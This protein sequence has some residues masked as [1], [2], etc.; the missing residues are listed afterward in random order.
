MHRTAITLS[1]F[2][3]FALSIP[4]HATLINGG[5]EQPVI[6]PGEAKDFEAKDIPGW[7]FAS[8]QTRTIHRDFATAEGEQFLALNGVAA[9]YIVQE[10]SIVEG[11]QYQFDFF[12]SLPL[13]PDGNGIPEHA[14]SDTAGAF[15]FSLEYPSGTGLIPE[16]VELVVGP[17][18]RKIS[19]P[20][21]QL[22]SYQ[23]VAKAEAITVTFLD[24][25][26]SGYLID[27][28]SLT[29]VPEPASVLLL[30]LGL[31]GLAGFNR[32]KVKQKQAGTS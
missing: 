13:L 19:E 9:G 15:G 25:D 8:D 5:F 32:R 12:Y 18:Q 4:A 21:W 16:M 7:S 6:E 31:A 30:A 1:I 10:T 26:K 27:G 28:V 29:A 22:Y 23:F 14:N 17:G 3:C 24:L 2:I 20:D 11:L